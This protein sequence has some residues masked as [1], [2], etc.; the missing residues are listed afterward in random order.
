M[1]VNPARNRLV[2]MFNDLEK[3]ECHMKRIQLTDGMPSDIRRKEQSKQVNELAD[4][5]KDICSKS[6]LSYKE[7]NKAL[8]LADK[9]L[10]IEI[11]E[12]K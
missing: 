4:K 9:E 7:K 1:Y 12:T 11:I 5:I 8:Y 3:G 6:N 10:Y 2:E